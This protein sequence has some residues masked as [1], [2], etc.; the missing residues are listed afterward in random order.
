M[1]FI[2]SH[3]H[4]QDYNTKDAPQVIAQAKSMGFYKLIC[5]SVKQADW[6]NVLNMSLKYPD[7]IT[8]A[9]GLHPWYLSASDNSWH[10]KLEQILKEHPQVLIGECGLDRTKNPDIALQ[11]SIFANHVELAMKFRRGIII[12]SVKAD[13]LMEDF[14][15]KLKNIKF[16]IHS[17]SGSVE[18]LQRAIS[19]GG[20]ISFSPSIFRR[21]NCSDLIK[22]VPMSKVLLESDGPFQGDLTD[23]VDLYHRFSE[24]KNIKTA[25]LGK[26]LIDNFEEFTHA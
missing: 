4:L 25:D 26:Q 9:I 6:Q 23:V 3:I 22:S 21:S 1:Q 19:F 13:A 2:D 15:L 5:P 16:V 8:P 10:I 7:F 11:K 12:H 14:W 18:F 24:L 20:Y 17:F